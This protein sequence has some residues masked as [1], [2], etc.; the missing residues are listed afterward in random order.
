MAPPPRGCSCRTARERLADRRSP[1]AAVQAGHHGGVSVLLLFTSVWR[2]TGSF[3]CTD[4]SI[5]FVSISSNL[6]SAL[7]FNHLPHLLTHTHTRVKASARHHSRTLADGL[8]FLLQHAAKNS[9]ALSP[10]GAERA[11]SSACAVMSPRPHGKP[12]L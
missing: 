12:S 2:Q 6:C 5:L 10:L 3:C 7:I 1:H 11:S 9:G 8:F 4:E